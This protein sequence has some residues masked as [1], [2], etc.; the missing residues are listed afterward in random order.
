[1]PSDLVKRIDLDQIYPPFL[2][3]VLNVL[4]RCKAR[5]KEYHATRGTASWAYQH[6]L[7]A[8][9]LEGK[10]GKAAPAG[11]SAHNYGLAID[12]APDSDPETPGL[13]P[14]WTPKSFEVLGEEVKWE[15]LH[16]GD[17]YNDLP[18]VSWPGFVSGED[19]K[20]LQRI[21][22]ATPP[23]E[24][25]SRRRLAV[26]QYLNSLSEVSSKTAGIQGEVS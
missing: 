12:F 21:Y 2:E 14:I 3:L 18:H 24:K 6:K 1:M 22:K 17:S 5:G 26:W 13:Q 20:V 15:G 16:W 8:L 23:S 4:A 25:E 10:G 7:R 9:Y 19:M 11:L